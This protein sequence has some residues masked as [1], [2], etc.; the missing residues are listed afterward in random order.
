MALRAGDLLEREGNG[1]VTHSYYHPRP[2]SGTYGRDSRSV[3]VM[4]PKRPIA[5]RRRRPDVKTRRLF[6]Q[7][8]ASWKQDTMFSSSIH[9]VAM[10]PAYQ[11][12]MT[13]GEAVVPLILKAMSEDRS[14]SWFWAL[15]A[16]A[17]HDAAAGLETVDAAIEAWLN[18]GNEQSFI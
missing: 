7:L 15:Q 9:Q 5:P 3:S 2:A 11:S 8:V 6:N 13:L 10:H 14:S 18:W 1:Y 12:M 17:L 4:A 16:I